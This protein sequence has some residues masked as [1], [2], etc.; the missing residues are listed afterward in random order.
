LIA[1]LIIPAR[2]WAELRHLGLLGEVALGIADASVI[3][4]PGSL[5]ILIVLLVAGEPQH[6]WMFVIAAALG[7]T[8]GAYI[9][10]HI[11]EKGGKAELAKRFSHKKLERVYR[12]SEKY[13]VGAVAI[14]ALL[15]PPFPL[16]P[17]LLVAGAM[18]VP[19]KKFVIAYAVGRTLRYGIVAW[20]GLLYGPALIHD[21]QKY[22]KPII[23]S[24]VGL[25]VA[26]GIVAAIYI[27]RRKRKGLPVLHSAEK[28]AA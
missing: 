21:M 6:W 18:R 9:T 16:A 28:K 11:G 24:L 19:R 23:W 20:L 5:D 1:A 3:P 27:Y 26:G 17:F 8:L 4:T 12:W 13:G 10:F 14:P 22:S 7:S 15:P 2:V 25:G